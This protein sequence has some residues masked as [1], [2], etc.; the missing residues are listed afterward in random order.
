[1]LLLSEANEL[2]PF[3]WIKIQTSPFCKI[4]GSHSSFA[5]NSE[6]GIRR[7]VVGQVVSNVSKDYSAFIFIV[8]WSKKNLCFPTTWLREEDS[9]ILWN[10]RNS[11]PMKWCQ[12]SR[13]ESS[14]LFWV[15]QILPLFPALIY[16]LF[17][18]CEFSC[19]KYLLREFLWVFIQFC[20]GPS[21]NVKWHLDAYVF[22]EAVTPF[23]YSLF[24][25]WFVV[26]SSFQF[27][28]YF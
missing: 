22:C 7:S 11:R 23:V 19:T 1:V 17:F 5:N 8:K 13:Y 25:T 18:I 12:L 28:I 24:L 10:V 14:S 9:T 4:W 15:K 21:K 3:I 2:L 20:L 27:C 26:Q 6:L 16:F